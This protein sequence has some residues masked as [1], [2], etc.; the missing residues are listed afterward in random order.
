MASS[1]VPVQ[2]VHLPLACTY[3]LL[4]SV[5]PRGTVGGGSRHSCRPPWD[6]GSVDGADAS[7]LS[8]S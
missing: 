8:L 3:T 1:S 6:G 5:E 7:A 2:A 4:T